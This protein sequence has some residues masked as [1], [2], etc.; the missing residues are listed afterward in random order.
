LNFLLA[1]AQLLVDLELAP[2]VGNGDDCCS[3]WVIVVV[4]DV[5]S[6][7]MSLVHS[8]QQE[9]DISEVLTLFLLYPCYKFL[10]ICAM[11]LTGQGSSTTQNLRLPS[12]I[13]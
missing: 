10:P 8:P 2:E 11:G 7:S 3:N 13:T 12:T 5:D 1:I 4:K 9:Q 6:S